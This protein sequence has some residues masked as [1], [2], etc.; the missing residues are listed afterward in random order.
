MSAHSQP[1]DIRSIAWRSSRENEPIEILQR[2]DLLGRY[3]GAYFTAIE[4]LE[5][6]L[7]VL[8]DRGTGIHEADFIDY[9]IEPNAVLHIEPGR[10]HRFLHWSDF[11]AT[12]ILFPELPD[13]VAPRWE[14]QPARTT[15]TAADRRHVD[16][17]IGLV[18]D[19]QA[20][21]RTRLA[22]LMA[23]RSLRDLLFVRLGLGQM[24]ARNS[25][26]LPPAYV[27]FRRDLEQDVSVQT[28]MTARAER[29]GYSARTIS[30]ACRQVA[31]CTAKELV[32]QRIVLEAQRLLSQPGAT[33]ALVAQAVGFSEQTNFAK[34]FRRQTS[35]SPT[36]WLRSIEDSPVAHR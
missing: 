26:H 11:D 32:D 33:S 1:R 35:Q 30:R 5:F 3:P 19:E 2:R 24:H 27:A 36:G 13:G 12:L 21:D 7:I 29:I 15:L 31:G 6:H 22:R 25:V 16:Q 17:V 20:M 10:V 18:H 8:G 4:R 23:L 28:T 34:F 14:L 9:P